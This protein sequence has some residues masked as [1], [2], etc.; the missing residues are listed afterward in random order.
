MAKRIGNIDVIYTPMKRE[1]ENVWTEYGYE[2]KVLP[3]GWTK[4]A[5]RRPLPVAMIYEKDCTIALRDGVKI[6]ADVFRPVDSDLEKVPAILPWSIYGK[7][8]TGQFFF[9]QRTLYTNPLLSD[10]GKQSLDLFPWRLGIHR[11]WTSGLEKWEAPDPAEWI[12]RGYAVV[13]TDARGTFKSEGDM[14]VYGTQEG[15]DGHDAIEWI[16]TQVWCNGAVGMAGNSW[17]ASTQW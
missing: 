8:G 6:Y 13:N 2:K 17:L 3:K 15:R 5:G 1:L 9:N 16:G 12:Q 4:E 7:T 10:T 14:P 11:S